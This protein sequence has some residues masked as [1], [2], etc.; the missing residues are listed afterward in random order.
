VHCTA[1]RH[2]ARTDEYGSAQP[3]AEAEDAGGTTMLER[4]LARG[5]RSLVPALLGLAPAATHAAWCAA[6]APSQLR[7]VC[8]AA[9]RYW[10][11]DDVSRMLQWR[12]PADGGGGGGATLLHRLYRAEMLREQPSPWLLQC[13]LSAGADPGA[14][15]RSGSTSGQWAEQAA[16]D[17]ETV[18]RRWANGYHE[19]GQRRAG[20]LAAATLESRPSPSPSRRARLN[21]FT[22]PP[23]QSRGVHGP[24]CCCTV[25]GPYEMIPLHAPHQLHGHA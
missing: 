11:S 6:M 9:P 21:A 18:L 12:A 25:I 8:A 2:G 22:P 13:V 24:P 19:Y 5:N 7:C 3:E 14:R 20:A 10:A 16:A 15:D 4:L 1:C 17:D 23:C